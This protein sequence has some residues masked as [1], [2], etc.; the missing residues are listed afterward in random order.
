VAKRNASAKHRKQTAHRH[1]INGSVSVAS[2][3]GVQY[4]RNMAAN[5]LG[6][7]NMAAAKAAA[8]NGGSIMAATRSGV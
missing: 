4:Q 8:K 7:K 3:R 1:G 2:K 6:M 5:N